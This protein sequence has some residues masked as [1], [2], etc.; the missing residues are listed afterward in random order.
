MTE[1]SRIEEIR[2]SEQGLRAILNSI[3]D[4]VIATDRE[5]RITR[6]NPVAEKMTGWSFREAEGRPLEDVFR[7]VNSQTGEPVVNPVRDVMDSGNITGLGND[8]ILISRDGSEYQ[9]ADSASPVLNREGVITGAVMVFRDVTEDYRIREELEENRLFMSGILD[10]IREGISVLNRDLAIRYTNTL[11]EE[12]YKDNLPLTGKKCYA[13]Y[14]GRDKPCDPC[15]I[16]RSMQTGKTEFNIVPGLPGSPAEWLELYSYPFKDRESGEITGV[17]EFVRDITHRKR[18]EERERNLDRINRII[19]GA[20]N[21]EEMLDQVLKA[22]LDILQCDRAFLLFPCDPG[23]ATWKVPVER[24]SPSWPG[25]AKEGV[26]MPM[27]E[28]TG[29]SMEILLDAD[30]PVSFGPGSAHRVDSFSARE[31]R[32]KSILAAAL[33]PRVGKAWG[34]GLHQCSHPR[35]WKDHEKQLF[36]DISRRLADG[37]SSMLLLRDLQAS[38]KKLRITLDSIG[39]AVIATDAGCRVVRMNPVA[40]KLTGWKREEATGKPLSEVFDIVNSRTRQPLENP[41]EK[42]LREGKVVGLANHSMLISRDGNEYQIADSGAPIRDRE[43]DIKGVVIVFSDVTEEYMMR[44]ELHKAQRL[45]SVGTLAGGIAHDFNNILLE[46][47]G[48]I[49]LAGS[50]LTPDSEAYRCIADAEASLERV[51]SLTNQL[52][53]F[54]RGGAPV[55]EAVSI[56]ELIRDTA[57]FNLSGSKV[58]LDFRADRELWPADA[59]RG[60][61]SRVISNLVV[62]ARQ[63]MPEG[64][65]LHIRAENIEIAEDVY[66]LLEGGRYLKITVRDEGI[67]IAPRHLPR[68]FDPYFTTKQKGSGLGLTAVHSIIARHGGHITVDSEPGKG[69]TFVIYLPAARREEIKEIESGAGVGEASSH[70]MSGKVLLMDDDEMVRN[71]A[72]KMMNNIGLDVE[73][74]KEGEKAVEMYREAVDAEEPFDAVIMDL[75]VPGGMG[76]KKAVKEILQIDPDAR[77]LVSSGYSTDPVMANYHQYGFTGV[78]VKPYT[79]DEL[80]NALSRV[81]EE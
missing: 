17:I 61:V 60:Q 9:I 71:T 29:K 33:Y 50:M 35:V 2:R 67:G 45:E 37:L 69:T 79:M 63:A 18:E 55:K 43:G 4:A 68:V 36:K 80:V 42:V 39:D 81:L 16:L 64:G 31:Y 47:F 13:A 28:G 76:G 8:T 14:Q 23:A 48:N 10:N 38:E 19:L 58:K 32:V 1:N 54:S 41:G 44:E 25:A 66:P 75:T 70:R 5:G 78:V 26:E 15:P 7:I 12:W 56:T 30:G 46:L 34:F 21:L 3:G 77:V 53:T 57:G 72:A 62:N 6:I 20:E 40:E 22:T 49:S 51:K 11:M 59:D 24:T 27:N 73:K 74:A 52:L 65:N